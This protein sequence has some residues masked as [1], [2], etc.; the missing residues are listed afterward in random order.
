MARDALAFASMTDADV[1][2][3]GIVPPGDLRP[4]FTFYQPR[5]RGHAN[6]I[7]VRAL[8]V[9]DHG[10]E[11]TDEDGAGG[12]EPLLEFR[13]LHLDAPDERRPGYDVFGDAFG[14]L[15]G[16]V[17]E[18]RAARA[19]FASWLADPALRLSADAETPHFRRLSGEELEGLHIPPHRQALARAYRY[20]PAARATNGDEISLVA[21]PLWDWV[22]PRQRQWGTLDIITFA[23]GR[24]DDPAF[25]PRIARGTG[26]LRLDQGGLREFVALLERHAY[27]H[28]PLA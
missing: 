26:T 4:A 27:E 9:P 13:L 25:D 23:R 5:V 2:A 17:A 1:Q 15:E 28:D 24:L 3:A 18:Y 19:F 14:S 11:G 16:D 20:V 6:V 7:G 8:R 21:V 10:G 12:D 22:S